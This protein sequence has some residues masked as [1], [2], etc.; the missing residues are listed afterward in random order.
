MF[1]NTNNSFK[2]NLKIRQHCKKARTSQESCPYSA[3]L[4][5]ILNF[6]EHLKRFQ[7][8]SSFQIATCK[9]FEFENSH[10]PPRSG[11]VIIKMEE[12]M[13]LAYKFE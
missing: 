4:V 3:W 9:F 2:Q 8:S 7:F 10:S 1:K 5:S 12:T 11:L 6:E 13:T